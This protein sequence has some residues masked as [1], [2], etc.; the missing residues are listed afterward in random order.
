MANDISA[1]IPLWLGKGLASLRNTH[2][3]V[4][5][6]S[7][8]YNNQAASFGDKVRV[9][10]PPIKTAADFTPSMTIPTPTDSTHDKADIDLDQWKKTDFG[11]ND[12]ELSQIL[13]GQW[14]FQS[15][16]EACLIGLIEQINSYLWSK[17]HGAGG[18]FGFVGTAGTNPFASNSD[19]LPD[20][21]EVLT[22]NKSP[23]QNRRALLSP[24]AERAALK[25]A[26]FKDADKMG[27]NIV[28]AEGFL[29]RPFGFE[30]YVDQQVP[31]HTSGTGASYL[32]NG[33]ASAGAT[34]LTVDTGSGTILA[35]DIITIAGVT[36]TYNVASSV[37]GSSVT[38][39]T[40]DNPGGLLGAA[41]DN[42]A[43]T[44]KASHAVNLAIH[45]AAMQLVTR[46]LVAFT[47]EQMRMMGA[48]QLIAQGQMQD[49]LTKIYVR[50]SVYRGYGMHSVVFDSLFGAKV[51]RPELGVRIAG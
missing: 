15:N 33:A 46:P 41:A 14:A 29:G 10:K 39:I 45:P 1:L 2:A 28:K 34:T 37:G 31:T 26:D 38:S 20:A 5:N 23:L 13:D 47:Q 3:L 6:V 36:G 12:K 27:S 7:R 18:F 35:G 42:A 16:A 30:T 8:D 44:V 49:P 21:K 4:G 11:L 48:G 24:A 19:V 40:I 22:N 32:L 51:V 50:M 17:T 43:V 25:L 9:A